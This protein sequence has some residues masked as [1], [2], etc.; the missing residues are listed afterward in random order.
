MTS[1]TIK[2]DADS[3]TGYHVIISKDILHVFEQDHRHE[4]GMLVLFGNVGG[5]YV[6]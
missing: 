4:Y 6:R 5:I 1:S 3:G 2:H